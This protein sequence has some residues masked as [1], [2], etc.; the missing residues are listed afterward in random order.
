MDAPKENDP[1]AAKIFKCA[2]CNYLASNSEEMRD[3]INDAHGG[4]GHNLY[5]RIKPD[6]G[7]IG[8]LWYGFISGLIVGYI[9]G[10]ALVYSLGL[11]GLLSYLVLSALILSYAK[12]YD[13]K[14][15]RSFGIGCFGLILGLIIDAIMGYGAKKGTV[16][17]IL[18]FIISI[19]MAIGIY[20][21]ASL[22]L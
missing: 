9:I 18:V 21:L 17:K 19:G 14:F 4:S 3:H 15:L 5:S 7:D 6:Q 12:E 11:F 8:F 16:Y 20:M 10:Y 22:I 1:G 13:A 2:R